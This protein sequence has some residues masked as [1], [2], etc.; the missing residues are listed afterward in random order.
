[1]SQGEPSYASS[2]AGDAALHGSM[3]PPELHWSLQQ[4]WS[5]FSKMLQ[6]GGGQT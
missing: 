6:A 2:S 3:R 5:T 1:M 4:A